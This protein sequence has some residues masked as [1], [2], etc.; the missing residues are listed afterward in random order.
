MKQSSHFPP[1]AP[2][3]ARE[4]GPVWFIRVDKSSLVSADASTRKI[5]HHEIVTVGRSFAAALL[6]RLFGTNPRSHH[7]GATGRVRTGNQRLAI[8]CHCQLGQ[9]IPSTYGTPVRGLP[10]SCGNHGL[11]EIDDASIL[12][13]AH[14]GSGKLLFGCGLLFSVQSLSSAVR[15]V[16]EIAWSALCSRPSKIEMTRLKTI[17]FAHWV[18]SVCKTETPY[19]W[20][21][22][23]QD[24]NELR[25][26]SRCRARNWSGARHQRS[27]A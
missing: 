2:Q 3:R 5:W 6:P 15:N 22:L 24:Q 11:L 12:W 25:G 10:G 16:G 14:I 27:T 7:K 13:L 4:H 18:F 1:R 9:G 23:L 21:C 19:L 20:R 17:Y 26:W 8:L